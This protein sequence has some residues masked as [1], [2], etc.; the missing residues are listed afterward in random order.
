MSKKKPAAQPVKEVKKAAD[1]SPTE[2]QLM[3][4]LDD[5]AAVAKKDEVV[6]KAEEEE[7]V[8]KMMSSSDESS[9]DDE[10]EDDE[11]EDEA[12][13]SVAASSSEEEDDDDED[14][15]RKS[16]LERAEKDSTLRKGMRANDFLESFLAQTSDVLEDV[17][18][19]MQQSFDLHTER[20]A[21]FQRR[22]AKAL[23]SLGEAVT[24]IGSSVQELKKTFRKALGAPRNESISG[25][26]LT[27]EDL[28]QPQVGPQQ[29]NDHPLD[30]V[31]SQVITNW[32][33]QGLKK[34]MVEDDDVIM[35]EHHRYNPRALPEHLQKAA[36]R[37]LCGQQ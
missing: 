6:A 27:T 2:Q 5:L 30:A 7:V 28:V 13:K 23:V 25:R 31:K 19:G 24:E 12:K 4:A 34:G 21:D 14:Q 26:A 36:I 11:D 10:D 16:L 9:S 1:P 8:S 37:D 18:K 29:F 17:R 32:L 35:F 20:Q 15:T 22:L 3:K 33:L